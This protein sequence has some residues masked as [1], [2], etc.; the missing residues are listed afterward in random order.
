MALLSPSSSF[1]VR[2]EMGV[3][4]NVDSNK[5]HRNETP[6]VKMTS[7]KRVVI[8]FQKFFAKVVK[9]TELY[10]ISSILCHI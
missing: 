8:Q 10:F 5:E 4:S 1:I 6:I 7:I 3:E 2:Y 9:K